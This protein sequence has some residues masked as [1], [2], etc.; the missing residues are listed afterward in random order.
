MRTWRHRIDPGAR[1]VGPWVVLIALIAAGLA[2][3]STAAA[4]PALFPPEPVINETVTPFLDNA[5]DAARAVLV[6]PDRQV[7]VAGTAGGD[8]GVHRKPQAG[9]TTPT[10]T[11]TAG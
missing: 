8:F 1:H 3:P 2:T 4:A 5:D 11:S 6:E 9:S 10:S 7:L